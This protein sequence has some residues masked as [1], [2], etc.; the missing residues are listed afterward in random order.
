MNKTSSIQVKVLGEFLNQNSNSFIKI[1]PH[2]T[3]ETF[4]EQLLLSSASLITD[5]SINFEI[6]F[7]TKDEEK[8]TV[9]ATN[10]NQIQKSLLNKGSNDGSYEGDYFLLY[11][12]EKSHLDKDVNESKINYL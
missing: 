8:L 4:Y 10:Y 12:K 11:S 3:Y 5:K 1:D 9:N 7:I 2:I 6:C